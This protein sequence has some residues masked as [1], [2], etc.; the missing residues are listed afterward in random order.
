MQRFLGIDVGAETIKLVL[1]ERAD[2]GVSVIERRL[3]EHHKA[4]E[5]AL[6]T[7]LETV[8]WDALAGAAATGRASRMLAVDR[9]PT[10]AALAR[11][12]AHAIPGHVPGTVVSIGSHGFSVLELRGAD[13]HVYR[14][15]SR[16]SQGTGN[17]LRQLVERF[18][19][20]VAAASALC[21]DVDK[22]AALSGRCPVI[23]K[24]D[25]T[26]LANKGEDRA[27]ILAGLYDAVCD[28]V[29]A[30][31]KPDLSPPRVLLVGGV[32]RAPRVRANFARFLAARGLTLV[33][34]P[35]E[36]CLYLEALGAALVAVDHG[37][38]PPPRDRVLAGRHDAH[39]EK[40][41][42]LR[43]ALANVVRMPPQPPVPAD[44][45][46]RVTLGFDIGSTGSKALALDIEARTPLWEGYI[47][48]L[49]NPVG[50]A[51][52][53]AE[54]FLTE[55][56]AR[57][58]VVAVGA[59]GSGREIVG[60]LM[61]ACFG[62]EPIFVLNE[63][64][65]HAEGALYFDAEV[66]TIFEIGGQD[67]KYIRLD[68]GRICEAA[69]NEACSAGTGSFIAE[70]GGKFKGVT[71][72]VQLGKVALEAGCGV[73]LGQHCSVFMAE[74]I[75]EAV[76]AG[77]DR[78]QIV[79]GI[80]DSIIQNYLNRVK[81]PRTVGKRVFCQGMPFMADALAAAVARQT[82]RQVIIPPNPGTIGALGIALL[83]TR[84]VADADR[85]LDLDQ[86]LAAKVISKDRFVCKSTRGCGGAGN[87]CK[88]DRIR[89][90]V[91]GRKQPPFLW[92]GNCSLFDAGIR[93]RTLPDR[94]PDPFRERAELL[95]AIAAD[96]RAAPPGA[97]RVVMSDEFTLK[98]LLPFFATF[99]R[100]LGFSVQVVGNATGVDLKRGI[101]GASVPYC[102]PM[103]IH[104]GVIARILDDRPDLLFLPRLRELPRVKDETHAVTCPI[105]QAGPDLVAHMTKGTATRIISPRI[106]IGP[107]NYGS[108]RFR[109][110]ALAVARE[111]G[112]EDRFADAFAAAVG[113]Q[114]R[115]ETACEEIGRRALAFASEHGV[116]PVVVLGRPYTIYN[117]VLNSNVPDLL[118]EQGAL[119]VP[120]D[121]YPVA[122]DVPVFGDLYWGHG[123]RNL[124]AAHQI[125]RA[126]GVYALYCSNYSCGPDSFNLH[127]FAYVMENKPFA[128][129]ET[130]G[131]SGDAGT[132]TRIEAFLHCVES[133]RR[134][135]AE[136]RARLRRSDFTA[137]D[138]GQRSIADAGRRGELMLLPRMGP[139]AE[140][141][142]ATL[143]GEGM[144][145]ECLPLPTQAM[146]RIGRRHTSGKECIPMAI[147]AGSLLE[148]LEREPDPARRFAFVMPGANGPCRFGAYNMLHKII[149][150][151]TGW[152]DRVRVLSPKDNH[153]FA[154]LSVDIQVR[155]CVYL[156]AADLLLAALHHVRPVER[157]HGAADAI[158][159]RY[160]DQLI[161]LV[162]AVPP[163][164]MMRALAE[165]GNGAFGVRRLLARAAGEFA[166][167]ADLDRDLP[168]VAM[169]GEIYVRLDPFANDFLVD[170]LEARG[171]RVRM[172]PFS[173]WLEYMTELR[174]QRLDEGRPLPTDK[175][176]PTLFSKTLQQ[177]V[178]DKLWHVVGEPL[179]WGPRQTVP[180]ALDAA[181]PYLSRQLM[182]EAVLTLGGPVWEHHHGAIDGVVAVGPHECMPNKIAEAQLAHVAEAEGLLSLALPVNGDPID[183]EILDRFAF[184]VTA[185]HAAGRRTGGAGHRPRPAGPS[186]ALL[187]ALRFL[188]GGGGIPLPPPLVPLANLVR[189]PS[190]R[191]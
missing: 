31:L 159:R 69:M 8:D 132:K 140:V 41:P 46:R 80:Y 13:H 32:M 187:A 81:G 171:L 33:D 43:D 22:P 97:R 4:P 173:E 157:E 1:L 186:R 88:I 11:G 137:I 34:V 107:G 131:H 45:S 164:T 55:T 79:A 133:D 155:S 111:L 116:V 58:Q 143:R 145:A 191:T 179:G 110:S 2:T 3:V 87:K 40:V 20:D 160:F 63:I 30:L 77:V 125:R 180:D 117:T 181:A 190:S 120:V 48:T 23:L 51:R 71:D 44:R 91:A 96:D 74:V 26:H 123:Q 21:A 38:R 86:F 98:G 70:Q 95:A 130:D 147:T 101:A 150:E 139:G 114:R 35:A 189:R 25:M 182:G 83:A 141:V 17:F 151:K 166:A 121:C 14:E 64:A 129:I 172:A 59:T 154:G 54:M 152:R 18:E 15:N 6:A 105:V 65:A 60:S 127:F 90:E 177:G 57:H 185:H 128:V 142:A 109:D 167:A 78:P 148:R 42:A 7:A 153:Y 108:P 61:A 62:P 53:L 135:A 144:A 162:G 183:P 89:T 94:A 113:E 9:V 39:F 36:D 5:A 112:A 136:E 37:R 50:A 168:T 102:A 82:G 10:K 66:D 138:G 188:P 16:C 176:L 12:V 175:R 119:A 76:A 104:H 106:D 29:Q 161:E 99:V 19:L 68:A 28:N 170:K 118:R 52:T 85:A 156:L 163:G 92:G 158:Y 122:D 84:E 73:S 47:N 169:V 134:L 56:G 24:T 174:L 126:D 124:R 149:L 27:A 115:F 184:E 67:A 93:R 165:L 49:G 75:D 100:R 146:L 178:A 103:Q 72:V